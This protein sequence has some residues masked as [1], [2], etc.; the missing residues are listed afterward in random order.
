MF[1]LPTRPFHSEKGGD[2]RQAVALDGGRIVMGLCTPLWA[3]L[4][5]HVLHEGP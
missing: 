5:L 3:T 1:K 4:A 2:L